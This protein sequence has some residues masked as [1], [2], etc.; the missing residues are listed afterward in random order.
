MT[1]SKT[2]IEG[3]FDPSESMAV[4]ARILSKGMSKLIQPLANTD[5]A[6]LTLNQLKMNLNCQNPKYAQDT[7][8]YSSPGG[9]SILYAASTRIFLTMRNS[10]D[11][12]VLDERGYRIGSEVK[13]KIV[14]SR[15]GTQGRECNFKIIWADAEK[16]GVLNDDS[17]FEAITPFIQQFGSYYSLDGQEKFQRSQWS[18]LMKKEDF[19]KKVLDIVE[20]E[21]II[22]F[23]K[24][25]ADASLFYG[26]EEESNSDE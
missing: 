20:K 7:E 22:K 4:K 9:K 2:D 8:K 25:E 17:I 12:Y 3:T 13:A 1:P 10:K 19:K 24:R 5:S 23:D 16:I 14:K 11:S 15:F 21:I 26:S 6:L 18:E